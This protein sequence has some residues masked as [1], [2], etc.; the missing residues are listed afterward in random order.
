MQIKIKKTFTLS[1]QSAKYDQ[2]P[3]LHA[4]NATQHIPPNALYDTGRGRCAQRR[5][6]SPLVRRRTCREFSGWTDR[7]RWT[8]HQFQLRQHPPACER[9]LLSNG[10]NLNKALRYQDFVLLWFF[11]LS[12][13]LTRVACQ[14]N[15]EKLQKN[16]ETANARKLFEKTTAIHGSVKVR[17]M[18]WVY[19]NTRST[20]PRQKNILYSNIKW[21]Q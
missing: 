15:V 17:R 5:R 8:R 19:L 2:R 20:K 3:P 9:M 13:L 21:R 14:R 16:D 12:T 10:V 4:M 18:R 1:P 7:T 11:T 6:S